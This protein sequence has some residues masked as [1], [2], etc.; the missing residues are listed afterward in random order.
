MREVPMYTCEP[1]M[2]FVSHGILIP[3]LW[4]LTSCEDRRRYALQ[5]LRIYP[6]RDRQTKESLARRRPLPPPTR[7]DVNEGRAK[8]IS[9]VHSHLPRREDTLCDYRDSIC[10]RSC[11]A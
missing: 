5:L 4:H 1:Y 2:Y 6:C 9:R 3:G 7:I 10:C 8:G 11:R